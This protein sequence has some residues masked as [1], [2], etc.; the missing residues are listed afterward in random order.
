MKKMRQVSVAVFAS[1]IMFV[2][3]VAT[4][5]LAGDLGECAGGNFSRSYAVSDLPQTF[6]QETPFATMCLNNDMEDGVHVQLLFN[7][8]GKKTGKILL[9]GCVPGAELEV[10]PNQPV[11]KN[12]HL[13][14]GERCL[15]QILSD[16]T[17]TFVEVTMSVF[18]KV[19]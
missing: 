12:P 4:P 11:V 13:K 7:T 14:N 15:Q 3:M 18:P 17:D 16:P 2:T 1:V 8:I 6:V 9:Q 10:P 5:A 19:V